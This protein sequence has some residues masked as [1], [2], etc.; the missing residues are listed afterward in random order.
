MTFGLFVITI[1]DAYYV[2]FLRMN[3]S[4]TSV[5]C[6]CTLSLENTSS[7]MLITVLRW[8]CYG[9]SSVTTASNQANGRLIGLSK[10][11]MILTKSGH[12]CHKLGW[13][14]CINVTNYSSC[15]GD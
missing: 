6:G 7:Q 10:L 2:N 5:R 15:G 9:D 4:S 11:A 3:H 14:H 1:F 13:I 8:Y 12:S